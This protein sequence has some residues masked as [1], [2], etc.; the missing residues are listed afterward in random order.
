MLRN[1][2]MM[3]MMVV[4][5][6]VFWIALMMLVMGLTECFMDSS[7]YVATFKVAAIAIVTIGLALFYFSGFAYVRISGDRSFLRAGSVG[8]GM[9]CALAALA[10]IMPDIDEPQPSAH[11]ARDLLGILFLAI[12]YAFS[13]LGG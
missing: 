12:P 9:M 3:L 13:V 4:G 8:L 2:G 10:M 1:F 7:N 5:G 11:S 6:V